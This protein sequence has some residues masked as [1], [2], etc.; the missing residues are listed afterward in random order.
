[1]VAGGFSAFGLSKLHF[2]ENNVKIDKKYYQQKILPVYF[3]ATNKSLFKHKKHL[4]FQQNGAPDHRSK[5]TM[6]ILNSHYQKVWGVGVWPGNS[7]DLNPIENLWAVLKDSIYIEPIST[8]IDA[9]K[10]D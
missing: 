5:C 9:L 10:I 2:I 6:Q 1:M 8:T 4:T 7:P 3:E